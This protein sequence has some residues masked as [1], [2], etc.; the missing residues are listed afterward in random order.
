MTLND[1]KV[2]ESA[3]VI[4]VGGEGSLRQHFLDMGIIPGAEV[5]LVKMAP[6]GDP[7]EIKIHGYALTLRVSE[8]LN[9]DVDTDCTQE[10]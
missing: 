5:N 1:L 4:N 3:V 7:M 6:M 10:P 8:A 2:G 9:I